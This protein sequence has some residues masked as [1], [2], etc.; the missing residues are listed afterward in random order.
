MVAAKHTVIP[1]PLEVEG[2][3]L[4][5]SEDDAFEPPV[6]HVRDVEDAVVEREAPPQLLPARAS[7]FEK[8]A[9]VSP[10]QEMVV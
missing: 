7:K 2:A 5:V 8:G 6:K 4:L 1:E 9:T 3:T 10:K